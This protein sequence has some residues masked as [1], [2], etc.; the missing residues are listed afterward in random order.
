MKLVNPVTIN[1]VSWGMFLALAWAT[2]LETLVNTHGFIEQVI[3]A[4][5]LPENCSQRMRVGS[6]S[7]GPWF[8]GPL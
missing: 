1:L 7:E 8:S 6:A 3:Y 2:S 4:D 5:L